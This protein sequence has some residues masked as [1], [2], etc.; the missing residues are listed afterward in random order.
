MKT[1]SHS[2]R[3][4]AISPVSALI[5]AVSLSLS[6]FCFWKAAPET[7]ATDTGVQRT[8]AAPIRSQGDPR[9]RPIE[10][11][12]VGDRVAGSNPLEEP[13]T[14]LGTTIDPA[15]WKLLA[16]T[17]RKSNDTTA[18][19]R[20]LRP[21]WWIADQD[22]E[23][24]RTVAL[25]LTEMGIDGDC[26]VLSIDACPK[27]VAGPGSVVTG[28]FRHKAAE[29]LHVFLD[30][31]DEPIGTTPNHPF[32]S[33]DRQDFVRADSLQSGEQLRTSTGLIRV[34]SLSPR[35]PPQPVFN[36]EVFGQHVYH[37]ASHG[38]LVHN[39]SAVGDDLARRFA[40]DAPRRGPG[41]IDDSANFAQKTF[42]EAFSEG[43]KFSGKT[44][45]DVAAMLRS[46]QLKP[47]DVP[48]EFFTRGNG[49]TLILNTRSA[50]ALRRAGIP[51]SQ[52]HGVDISGNIPALKRLAGQLNRNDLW[53]N[54]IPTVR[55]SGGQ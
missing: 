37:V 48:L 20:L 31:V 35:G 50:E 45:D 21:D 38:V 53:P 51:R 9:T 32:W 4:G 44:I 22:I 17:A 16:L 26:R 40:G 19:I 55:P 47:S 36:I 5:L 11:I 2:T 54:G 49:Q 30:G 34:K 6:G 23:V 13:D 25:D 7:T 29:T 15:T 33:E 27:I 1:S 3:R 46:D 18:S 8:S 39:N 52:W 43:G 41:L 10:Q 42:S 24:G 12:V 28:T 14:S